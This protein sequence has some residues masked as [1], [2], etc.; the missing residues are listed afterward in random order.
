M[1]ICWKVTF[2]AGLTGALPPLSY[3]QDAKTYGDA[4]QP[5]AIETVDVNGVDLIT[6]KLRIRSPV[7]ATGSPQA[8]KVLGLE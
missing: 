6:G 3:A 2:V 5:A 1:R 4:P 8:R 7:I